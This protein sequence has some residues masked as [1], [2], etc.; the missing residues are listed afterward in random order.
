[1][2]S[3]LTP[4]RRTIVSFQPENLPRIAS[5]AFTGQH[6]LS[7]QELTAL[8]AKVV[9]GQGY[10]ERHFREAVELNLRSAYERHGM[11]RVRFPSITARKISASSVAVTTAVEEGSQ[12]TLGDVQFVGEHLPTDAMFEAAQFKKGEIAN[13]AE[14]QRGIWDSERP[15]KRFG[16]LMAVANPQRIFDDERHVLNLKIPFTLGPLYRFGKLTV[17]GLPADWEERLRQQWKLQPGDPFDYDYGSE[18]MSDFVRSVND[19]PF[20][21]FNVRTSNG[22]QYV[23]D[24]ELIFEPR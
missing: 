4:R 19:R 14:I 11:Y 13:W 10:M 15:V 7:S 1:M 6:E 20:K 23:M 12:Y 5:M 8:L 22:G 2:E 9:A 24:F 21:R 17:T 16:Y 3:E 18:F